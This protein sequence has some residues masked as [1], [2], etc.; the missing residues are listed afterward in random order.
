MTLSQVIK[1]AD[2]DG[3]VDGRVALARSGFQQ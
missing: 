1:V 2:V 3:R